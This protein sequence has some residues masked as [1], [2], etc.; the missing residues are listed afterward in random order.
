VILLGETGVGKEVTARAIHDRSRRAG[1]PFV[2]VNCAAIAESLL[3]SE[4]FGY[5][6]GAFTGAVAKKTGLIEAANGGTLFL[7]EVG[8]TSAAVQAK[9]LRTLEAREIRRVGGVESHAVDVRFVAATNR[10]LPALVE[11]GVFRRDLYFR[12]NGLTIEIPPLRKRLDELPG[13]AAEFL[14][15][16]AHADALPVQTLSVA[17]LA[18]LRGHP[19]P[20]NVRELRN[21]MGR[22]VLL[23]K[24]GE[25]RPE[26]L[27][28]DSTTD[29][30][31]AAPVPASSS[32][33]PLHEEID[34]LER[35]R[36]LAA[37]EQSA[38][39]QTR[40]AALL[41]IARRTLIH[42]M[43]EY[44]LPRPRKKD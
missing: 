5:E 33:T 21:L 42:R 32:R 3:D 9:L 19:F 40:A 18:V 15:E 17:A 6:K 1:K 41:G 23:S 22:A 28:L 26:H 35:R 12:L 14:R 34:A 11:S 27:R 39:N 29:Q 31:E 10:D 24:G 16:V 13:L 43:Q 38:G 30:R 25:V 4:L 20:G 8:E 37:L 36:V 2:Q 44:G 7:D